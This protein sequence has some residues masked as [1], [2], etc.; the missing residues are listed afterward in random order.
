M[1]AGGLV[2]FTEQDVQ[3]GGSTPRR[4]RV[5]SIFQQKTIK[6]DDIDAEFLKHVQFAAQRSLPTPAALADPVSALDVQPGLSAPETVSGIAAASSSSMLVMTE[7]VAIEEFTLDKIEQSIADIEAELGWT[8]EGAAAKS[9]VSIAPTSEDNVTSTAAP[10]G[11][12]STAHA[13]RVLAAPQAAAAGT[14][15]ALPE[16]PHPIRLSFMGELTSPEPSRRASQAASSAAAAATIAKPE[17]GNSLSVMPSSIAVADTKKEA[18]A[19]SNSAAEQPTI[20]SFAESSLQEMPRLSLE[21]SPQLDHSL[22]EANLGSLSSRSLDASKRQLTSLHS[23]QSKPSQEAS[24]KRAV[25]HSASGK[26]AVPGPSG[27][28]SSR[29]ANRQLSGKASPLPSESGLSSGKRSLVTSPTASVHGGQGIPA[30]LAGRLS[31]GRPATAAGADD[32]P[33]Q[34]LAGAAATLS[35]KMHARP[36][37]PE[38][39]GWHLATGDGLPF[40]PRGSLV[41]SSGGSKTLRPITSQ[42]EALFDAEGNMLPRHEGHNLEAEGV[43]LHTAQ[44]MA[45]PAAAADAAKLKAKAQSKLGAKQGMDTGSAPQQDLINAKMAEKDARHKPKHGMLSIVMFPCICMR[46]RTTS[47]EDPYLHGSLRQRYADKE[48]ASPP[49]MASLS[50]KGMLASKSTLKQKQLGSALVTDPSN[51]GWDLGTHVHQ[52]DAAGTDSSEV[53]LREAEDGQSEEQ[54]GKSLQGAISL[55][56]KR[57]GFADAKE[58]HGSLQET[59]LMEDVISPDASFTSQRSTKSMVPGTEALAMSESESHADTQS[60]LRTQT[61]SQSHE[62][63]AEG[64]ASSAA[65]A[66]GNQEVSPVA[67]READ[68]SGGGPTLEWG[69]GTRDSAC[70]KS[71]TQRR[72][73]WEAP[74]VGTPNEVSQSLEDMMLQRFPDLQ[75]LLVQSS[76]TNKSAPWRP[77]KSGHTS[78]AASRSTSLG[79]SREASFTH[80]RPES[81]TGRLPLSHLGDT[82]IQAAPV[83]EPFQAGAAGSGRT[84]MLDNGRMANQTAQHRRVHDEEEGSD[85]RG[86]MPL[87]EAAALGASSPGAVVRVPTSTTL[88]QADQIALRYQHQASNVQFQLQQT[89]GGSAAAPTSGRSASKSP[90]RRSPTKH[91]PFHLSDSPWK[92]SSSDTAPVGNSQTL[93]AANWQSASPRKGRSPSRTKGLSA[94]GASPVKK[95][96]ERRSHQTERQS[97]A[98]GVG[99]SRA[100]YNPGV[101]SFGSYGGVAFS[102]FAP[103]MPAGMVETDDAA[104]D[105]DEEDWADESGKWGELTR[106]TPAAISN[107]AVVTA[108][109]PALAAA[110]QG[111]QPKQS[112]ISL[113]AITADAAEEEESEAVDVLPD[114]ASGGSG[115]GGAGGKEGL[116]VPGTEASR[117]Y[118]SLLESL[119]QEGE[120]GSPGNSDFEPS[121]TAARMPKQQ[122]PWRERQ[123][124]GRKDEASS[125]RVQ[126]SEAAAAEPVNAEVSHALSDISD[127][128]FGDDA[129]EALLPDEA[130]DAH[131]HANAA[132]HQSQLPALSSYHW[133]PP[134][135]QADD[136]QTGGA[137]PEPAEQ[138]SALALALVALAATAARKQSA[139]QA[140]QQPLQQSVFAAAAAEA[141]PAEDQVSLSSASS[142]DVLADAA[143]AAAAA[144]LPRLREAPPPQ[145]PEATSAA[146]QSSQ[147]SGRPVSNHPG[148]AQAD[149]AEFESQSAQQAQQE[150]KSQR[151]S[152]S[153][154]W[155]GPASSAPSWSGV[156]DNAHG[157]GQFQAKHNINY[158]GKSARRPKSDILG[159]D[160]YLQVATPPPKVGRLQGFISKLRRGGSK[161]EEESDLSR[162]ASIAGPRPLD[163][164]AEFVPATKSGTW[165]P[166][167]FSRSGSDSAALPSSPAAPQ[168]RTRFADEPTLASQA[169]QPDLKEEQDVPL[170]S[171]QAPPETF[172]ALPSLPVPGPIAADPLLPAASATSASKTSQVSAAAPASRGGSKGM[173]ASG[174]LVVRQEMSQG[175]QMQQSSNG[176]GSDDEISEMSV[177]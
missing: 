28:Y 50:S 87:V 103:A 150:G 49:Q 99:T 125:S 112:S 174:L 34:T 81:R 52:A 122:Q 20:L 38:G 77:I 78:H 118:L 133:L 147:A 157:I 1:Q 66:E 14:P 119:A 36:S 148:A 17:S 116:H 75:A 155:P 170:P 80:S 92:S 152:A 42:Q 63:E 4:S 12:R 167:A 163:S 135:T 159:G 73:E 53:E 48:V 149:E 156:A 115:V 70:S 173:K 45:K 110:L 5:S 61:R 95:Q 177:E 37:S 90:A 130:S 41:A 154:D 140:Q 10:S 26:I 127:L 172:T 106:T 102:S 93:P 21:G 69:A 153:G 162:P 134:S 114:Q 71:T 138:P 176:S 98:A 158:V 123:S 82:A 58:A 141:S 74:E 40:S 72:K 88:S 59:F 3:S 23:M 91:R 7:P 35:G 97:P 94:K 62:D 109:P 166:K 68:A 169:A 105:V 121:P 76:F 13:S 86:M 55:A 39:A 175:R 136:I 47:A 9:I 8:S 22:R 124:Q 15:H 107:P 131:M 56:P 164:E 57:G 51:A 101:M 84:V 33:G 65:A 113:A 30:H 96:A 64:A 46:P 83:G 171:R 137:M 161:A 18:V 43:Q 120:F 2:A 160:A 79:V 85:D 108:G 89:M 6:P 168:G 146:D 104:A 139:Q 100:A 142:G 54:T 143:A 25:R 126:H 60:R 145:Q 32:R 67:A 11:I 31:G 24:K 129:V 117:S 128:N 132:D 151:E 19:D 111:P 27:S 16:L 29:Y 165:M 44:P 144:G